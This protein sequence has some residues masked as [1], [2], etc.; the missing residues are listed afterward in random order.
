[1]AEKKEKKKIV[2][3]VKEEP[4]K[5]PFKIFDQPW[6]VSYMIARDIAYEFVDPVVD[7]I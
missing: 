4:V 7:F 3:V 1:M 5:I 2:E 6:A